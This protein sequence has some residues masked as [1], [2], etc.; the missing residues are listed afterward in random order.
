[1]PTK[2]VRRYGLDSIVPSL[3]ASAFAGA[4]F[5]AAPHSAAAQTCPSA[6]PPPN[7]SAPEATMVPPDVCI[8]AGLSGNPIAFFDDYSWRAFV[9]LVWQ[10]MPQAPTSGN[11][12]RGIPDTTKTIADSSAPLVFETYKADWETFQP[13]G[14][15]PSAFTSYDA[16][17]PCPNAK[18]G[19]FVLGSLTKFGN[20]GQAGVGNLVSV[21]VSQNGK[22]VRYLA[23]YNQTEFDHILSNE[24]YLAANLGSSQSPIVFPQGSVDIKSSWI[25]MTTAVAHP[26]RVFTRNAWLQDPISGDCGAAPVSVGLVGLHIVQKT[27]TRPQWIW[28]TF[29]QIDNVP[30]PDYVPPTPPALP[31]QTFTFNDGT[32]TQMDTSV[33]PNYL[34]SNAKEASAP[35]APINIVRRSNFPIHP[36]TAATNAI[37]QAALEAENSVWQFYALTM[38]QWPLAASTPGNPGTPANTFPGNGATSAFANTT[39][40]TWDQTN[41]RNGC[42]NCHNFTMVNDFLWSLEMNAYTPPS[43]ATTETS[44]GVRPLQERPDI[45]GLRGLLQEHAE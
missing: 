15:K 32:N 39:L 36:S 11:S 40:E 19:D 33:P 9:S 6:P 45:A 20:V 38:T 4:A 42:M 16:S 3:A 27:P 23:A 34:W 24:Y 17:P 18:P 8:P 12:P 44:A 28:S 10:A 25:E 7:L 5:V 30:P 37:W 43:V 21:L 41:V 22:F 35:P 31:T 13:D 29:E 1:M 14:A 2:L 26:E